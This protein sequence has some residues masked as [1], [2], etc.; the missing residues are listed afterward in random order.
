[1]TTLALVFVL[2]LAANLL[3]CEW[4]SARE[5]GRLVQLGSLTFVG[6]CMEWFPLYVAI[7]SQNVSLVLASIVGSVIGSVWGGARERARALEEAEDCQCCHCKAN[8]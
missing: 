6:E 7:G 1:M 4:Q 2:S 8:R 3:A 5:R